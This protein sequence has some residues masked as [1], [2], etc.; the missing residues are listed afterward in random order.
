MELPDHISYS[1]APSIK[2]Q[3][4]IDLGLTV[5]TILRPIRTNSSIDVLC[6][7]L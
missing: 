6:Y 2:N 1:I 3:L 5:K 4:I 7:D